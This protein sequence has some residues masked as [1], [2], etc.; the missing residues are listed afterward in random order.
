M[1]LLGLDLKRSVV[2]RIVVFDG[3]NRK[4]PEGSEEASCSDERRGFFTIY[5]HSI[6]RKNGLYT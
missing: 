6:R 3:A 5:T 4:N 1:Y 2:A